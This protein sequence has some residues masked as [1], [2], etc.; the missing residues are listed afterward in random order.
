MMTLAW[1][2][3]DVVGRRKLML[4]CSAILVLSFIL[5]TVFGGLIMERLSGI[6][7][8]A[9]AIIGVVI[10]YIATAA[11]G[12]GWLPQPWLIPTEIYPS[13]ARAKGAAIS[14]VVWGFANFSV[15][16]LSPIL[17]NNFKYWIFA[18]FAVTNALAGLW[19]WASPSLSSMSTSRLTL[20]QVYS[21]ETGGRT[22]EENVQFFDDAEDAGTWRVRKVDG[23]LYTR[24]PTSEKGKD[25]DETSPLLQ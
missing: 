5:L 21:P 3:I 13:A 15:T 18:V 10:L 8:L 24:M 19:T 7:T 20:V 6:P 11:F 2:L 22:F 17:F 9:L 4:W 14:V 25:D 16:F 12:V 1:L 23:G